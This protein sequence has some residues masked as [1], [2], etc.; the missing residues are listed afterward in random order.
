M[1]ETL[2]IH[3]GILVSVQKKISNVLVES[4]SQIT[5][6][7]IAGAVKVTSQICNIITD[8]IVLASA[9]RNRKFKNYD[10]SANKLVHLSVRKA[11]SC[12]IQ[13][14]FFV[15]NKFSFIVFFQKNKNLQV[16]FIG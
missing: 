5:I 10:R 11:R 15:V 16:S 8:I 13:T 2:A 6:Q 3:E 12:I 9:I 1:V 4:D 7:V 14:P